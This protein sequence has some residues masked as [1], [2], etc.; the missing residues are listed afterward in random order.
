MPKFNFGLSSELANADIGEGFYVGDAPPKGIYTCDVKQF[1]V[2]ANKNDDHMLKV[3]LEVHEKGAKSK[4]NGYGI[5]QNLNVT[6]QGAPYINNLLDA[7]GVKRALFWSGSVVVDDEKPPN[8]M[9]I[10]P[11][12]V[13]GLQVR[14]A[15][16]TGNWNGD[17]RLEVV[18]YLVG[19][20]EETAPD[21]DDA[22]DNSAL[23]D[24][25]ASVALEDEAE[26]EA[27]SE[28]DDE[29]FSEEDL[30]ELNPQELKAILDSWEIEY[31]AKATKA[32]LVKAILKAQEDA[33]EEEAEEEEAEEAEEAE[34]IETEV[35][36]EEDLIELS[37]SELKEIYASREWDLPKPPVKSKLVKGILV[38]Q[39]EPPF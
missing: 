17:D 2:G 28:D 22:E 33:G 5:W 1:K 11:R 7:L 14:V 24:D 6:D 34:E 18:R 12:K 27:A 30:I 32:T 25:E 13:V 9:K 16:K 37:P 21:D 20:D 35:Y 3:L 29:A 4:Y 23:A 31:A 39:A 36:S 15:T 19:E 10:G 38:A 26:E 8:V